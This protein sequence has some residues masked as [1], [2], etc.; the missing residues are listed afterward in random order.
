MLALTV[1]LDRPAYTPCSPHRRSCNP[2]EAYGQLR[3]DVNSPLVNRWVPFDATCRAPMLMASLGRLVWA[4]RDV[5]DL[6]SPLAQ[7][8][9]I[10]EDAAPDGFDWEDME[11]ARGK[12][13]V[14]HGDSLVRFQNIH[15]C[16]VRLYTITLM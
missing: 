8:E 6:D 10:M 3:I 7:A 4:G 12:T 1:A 14:A 15:F 13:V 16:K 2:Y 5:K 9:G 11:W